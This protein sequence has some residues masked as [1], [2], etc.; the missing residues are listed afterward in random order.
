MDHHK[1]TIAKTASW[2]I[3]AF[4]VSSGILYLFNGD[5][6]RSFAIIGSADFLKIF[7]YYFHERIWNRIEFGRKKPIE[8]QI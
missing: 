2:R 3:L 4:F 7:L 8:Y 6:P 5:A 1:R